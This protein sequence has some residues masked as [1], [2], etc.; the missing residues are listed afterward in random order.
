MNGLLAGILLSFFPPLLNWRL[1]SFIRK[2]CS[3]LIL[4]LLESSAPVQSSQAQQLPERTQ[5]GQTYHPP[6]EEDIVMLESMGFER[7]RIVEAMRVTQNDVQRAVQ[8]LLEN[9]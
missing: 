7:Q 4:P 9:N 3:D 6:N 1:P 5:E 8:I 2:L